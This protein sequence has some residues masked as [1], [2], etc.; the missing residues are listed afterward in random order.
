MIE[1]VIFDLDGT[2][3]YTLEDLAESTNCA[4]EQFSYPKRSVQEI[5]RFVGNGVEKLIER[6]IP[7]GVENPDFEACL[8]F[9]K[10]H[11]SKNMYN[12]TRPYEGVREM[13]EALKARGVRCAVVSNKFD[14]AVK[15]LCVK[16][17]D[18]LI[19][20]AV[21]ETPVRRKKPAPDS[22]LAVLEEMDC[23]PSRCLYVG[24]SEVDIETAKN[25][26]IACV[27]VDWG[28]KDREFL[29]EHG[30]TRVVSSPKGLLSVI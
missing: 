23:A 20:T 17:F 16:Y 5:R 2:L 30:A 14:S 29:L 15:E 10:S 1:T 8:L 27:S 12:R 24:D 9:F 11:Y 7:N 26:G 21:G 6:A 22:V 4:L 3:L 25:S 19:E 13:L 18:G 28:Y